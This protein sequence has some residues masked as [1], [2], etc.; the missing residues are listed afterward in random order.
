MKYI[1]L[2]SSVDRA[3]DIA[4]PSVAGFVIVD[5]KESPDG[6]TRETVL[7]KL[8]NPPD[9]PVTVRIG[10]YKNPKANDGRGQTN[11]SIKGIGI[12][13]WVDADENPIVDDPLTGTI[14]FSVPG[15]Q[16]LPAA[17]TGTAE[18]HLVQ[19]LS[20]LFLF[21]VPLHNEV[22]GNSGEATIAEWSQFLPM[23]ILTTAAESHGS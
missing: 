21:A 16:G 8:G 12:G 7:Q 18:S 11:Y 22:N 4:Y 13:R 6:L 23:G 15:V 10:I 17:T 9:E 20:L 2:C 1:S 19:L 5:T 14:A 3:I